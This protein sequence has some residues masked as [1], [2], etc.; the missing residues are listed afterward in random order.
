[1]CKDAMGD[2]GFSNVYGAQC[3]AKQLSKISMP[4]EAD[5]RAFVR[6]LMLDEKG[7]VVVSVP[8]EMC[9]VDW[10]SD[11][12]EFLTSDAKARE[13]MLRTGED[14]GAT[15]SAGREQPTVTFKLTI[16]DAANTNG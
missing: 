5:V 6:H 13:E 9:I 11:C 4:S 7:K 10:D 2:Y 8:L 14:G 15:Q 12:T 16:S 3:T 1:M